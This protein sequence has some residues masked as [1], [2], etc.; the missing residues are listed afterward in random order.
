MTLDD[1]RTTASIRRALTIIAAAVAA[2]IALGGDALAWGDQGHRIVAEI[3]EQYLEANTARQ[4]R[5]LL[6]LGNATTLAQVS[7]WADDIRRERPETVP[8]HVVAIPYHLPVGM[9]R[10][11]DAA[12]DCPHDDCV[13]AA[14][15]RFAA[16]LHDR[17]APPRDRL[18][19]LD[20][21]VNL[22]G[23]IHQPLHCVDDGDRGGM[24][25]H[26]IFLGQHTNLHDLWGADMLRAKGIGDE[27]AYSLGLVRSIA[28]ARAAQWRGGTPADWAS[29][30]YGI[31][32][33]I[34]GGSYEAR[35]LAAF[36]EDDLL[37]V[38]NVQLEK[39]GLRLAAIL[40][41]ALD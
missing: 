33:L 30:S 28:P 1:P 7:T 22:V 31:A 37:S 16:V 21:V 10:A 29:E 34:Y 2:A 40:N 9:P 11:Y 5:E 35:A 32:R 15:E 41:A 14:I 23:D 38:V 4:V 24:D 39:A 8:W 18:E 27:P 36:Y 17:S 13:V 25:V 6:A 26:L 19:A 20:F 12:R 3:A